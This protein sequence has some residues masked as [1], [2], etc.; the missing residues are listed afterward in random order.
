MNTWQVLLAIALFGG[1]T[2]AFVIWA[3]VRD[4]RDRHNAAQIAF[5]L[6]VGADLHAHYR[7]LAYDSN[8]WR[9][10]AKLD[11]IRLCHEINKAIRRI[12]PRHPGVEIP[13]LK[14]EE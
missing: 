12:A 2:G 13:R 8:P 3:V 7:I 14:K 9:L 11:V 5:L 6:K 1:T 4:Q 10:N